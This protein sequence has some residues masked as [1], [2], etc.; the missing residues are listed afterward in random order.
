MGNK[1]D[2]L[3]DDARLEAL[4]GAAPTGGLPFFAISAATGEGCAALVAELGARVVVTD[5]GRTEA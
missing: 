3:T 5:A 2:I 4:S 1:T